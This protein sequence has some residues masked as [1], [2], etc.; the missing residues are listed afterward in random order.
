MQDVLDELADDMS[1]AVDESKW[2]GLLSGYIVSHTA[3]AWLP[4]V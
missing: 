4:I 2:T 3:A 1:M